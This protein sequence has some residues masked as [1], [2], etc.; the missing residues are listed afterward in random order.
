M[1]NDDVMRQNLTLMTCVLIVNVI[2]CLTPQ[3]CS[4]SPHCET[5]FQNHHHP[6]PPPTTTTAI[7]AET[8]EECVMKM[9][10]LIYCSSSVTVEERLEALD[11]CICQDC[12]W[13]IDNSAFKKFNQPRSYVVELTIDIKTSRIWIIRK[14]FKCSGQHFILIRSNSRAAASF[15]QHPSCSLMDGHLIS[16]GE[17]SLSWSLSLEEQDVQGIG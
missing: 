9:L 13:A 7:A 1:Y 15:T 3:C 17:Q 12:P 5:T 2:N 16:R 8:E 14:W 4:Y 6:N 11:G 10:F